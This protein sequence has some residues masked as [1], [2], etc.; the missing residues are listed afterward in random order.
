[1]NNI[2]N[3]ADQEKINRW[4]LILGAESQNRFS[5]MGGGLSVEQDLID[6]ALA[7][8]YNKTE[9]G[10]FGDSSGTNGRGAGNGPSNPQIT[11][12][13]G[14]VRTLFDKELVTVIQGDAMNRC[15]L[16]QLIFEPELLDNLEPDV[17]LASTI[18]LLKD[19]I[20]KRSKE[21][22]R[23]FI[24]KIVEEINKL[25]EQ[26]IRRV[27]TA[28]VNRRRHSPIPSAAALDYKMTISRNLKHYNRQLKTIVPEHFYFFD[29]T[30]TT[31]ANKW[32]IILDIDQSGSMGESVIYSSIISCILASMSSLKTHVVA[33]DTNIV[34]LTEKCDDPVD[35]LFGFQLGGGTDIDKSVAYCEQFIENPAKTLF[36]LISDLE[37]GGNRAALLRR[38]EEMKA[39][40]VTVVCLL[41][42]ADGGRPYYDAQM[43]GKISSMGIPCFACNPQMLP[44]LLGRALRGQDLNEFQKEFDKRKKS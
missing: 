42:L 9:Y 19:Q 10:G 21:S 23:V 15:G 38:V 22:V 30:S 20:P 37:E 16:K 2:N 31:A 44:E 11:R 29:R 12:W 40:G 1:M 36:F 14:D 33:F 28:A 13:L 25:L 17:S 27:V 5:S 24:R 6:Q 39:S 4:R 43:A 8:I 18:L 26:D 7:A 32:T 3:A 35:L 41:A 34:D